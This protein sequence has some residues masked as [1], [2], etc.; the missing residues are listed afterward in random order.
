MLRAAFRRLRASRERSKGQTL[1]LF[2]LSSVLIIALVALVIDVA[3]FW[4]NEQ[5]MQKAADAG[6]LA[7]AVYLP[8]NVSQAYT[9]ALAEAKKNGYV[10]GTNG[11][12]VRAGAA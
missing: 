7:G 12:T 5:Q 8:G 9:S 1:V 4:T 10:D 11:V 6:A 3:W 2:A